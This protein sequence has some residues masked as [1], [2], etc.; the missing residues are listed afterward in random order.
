MYKKYIKII[1]SVIIIGYISFCCAVYF[2]P[3]YFFYEPSQE[4]PNLS[5]A[6]AKGFNAQEVNYNSADG[7]KLYGWFVKPQKDQKV[8]VY[9][10]GNSYN[11]GAFYNK[12]IPFIENGYGVFIGEYRGFGGIKGVINEKNIAADA[13]AAITYLHSLGY[14][15]SSLIIYGM[16]LGSYSAINTVANQ[17]KEESFSALILEV[18]F[19]SL[20]NVV[21]ERIPNIFP[22]N[23]II[24]DKYDNIDNVVQIKLPVLVMGAENDTVVPISRAKNLYQYINSTKA[25]IIY[26][27][28]N[29]SDLYDNQNY[30][31]ILYWLKNNEKAK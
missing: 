2:Y 14:K 7:T 17:G 19:D 5:E 4:H 30:Q 15:N 22:F 10:H 12:L 13:N 31:D 3:Q 16:S 28:A 26:P 27:E 24:K 9:F 6:K 1:L 18:P 23:F 8:I 29:H 25:M 21:K 11:I 20:I